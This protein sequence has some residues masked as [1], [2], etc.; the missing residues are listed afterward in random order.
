MSPLILAAWL[1][2]AGDMPPPS[3]AEKPDVEVPVKCNAT[4]CIVPRQFLAEM[5]EAHNAQVDY[6]NELE[7]KVAAKDCK[8]PPKLK[9]ERRS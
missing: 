2:V 7:G 1:A 8:A 3:A 5:V 4:V 9:T 6:I